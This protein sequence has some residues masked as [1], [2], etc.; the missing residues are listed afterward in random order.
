M[1][2]IY[3]SAERR[4]F[5]PQDATELPGDAVPVKRSRYNKL[6][7][8]QEAGAEILPN[9]NGAPVAKHPPTAE[10]RALLGRQINR[11]ARRRITEIS[12]VWKQI[13]DTRSP[14]PAGAERFARI[15]AV[16]SASELIK[17]QVASAAT[18]ALDN[19]DIPTSPLWPEFD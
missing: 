19:I 14:T 10:R 1:N 4:G 2:Q 16:R 6:L 11:E 9:A 13:N 8:D 5:I 15:D 18:A 7:A 17:A 12:P 3:Y